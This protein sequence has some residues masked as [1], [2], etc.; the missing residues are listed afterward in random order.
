MQYWRI[1]LRT[2]ESFKKRISFNQYINLRIGCNFS[3]W[4][5]SLFVTRKII[6]C[7]RFITCFLSAFFLP[8]W[9]RNIRKHSGVT[10]EQSKA[11]QIVMKQ[12]LAENSQ[13]ALCFSSGRQNFRG[14]KLRALKVIGENAATGKKVL[15][16]ENFYKLTILINI[17]VLRP[18]QL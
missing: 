1:T 11:K 18:C 8:G 9:K 6:H 10:K 14:L 16:R 13:W 4:Y 17:L 15:W 7:N 12:F 5:E 2:R 3:S